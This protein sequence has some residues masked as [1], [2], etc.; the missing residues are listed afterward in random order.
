MGSGV[1]GGSV[2]S[3]YCLLVGCCQFLQEWPNGHDVVGFQGVSRGPGV[4]HFEPA[5]I[6]HTWR[7]ANLLK[8][9]KRKYIIS[10]SLEP[11]EHQCPN[12]ITL[13]SKPAYTVRSFSTSMD[14]RH[15]QKSD[16]AHRSS[17]YLTM[18]PRDHI[19]LVLELDS[20]QQ[21]Q[22][23]HFSGNQP[24]KFEPHPRLFERPENHHVY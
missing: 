6:Y 15:K 22:Y 3:R 19:L 21:L 20:I 12:N 17:L 8:S 24:V 1:G 2:G 13:P 10:E 4:R 16:K 9:L 5:G 18:T 7:L 14:T 11:K 23:S